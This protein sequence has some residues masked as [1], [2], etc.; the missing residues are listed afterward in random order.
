MRKNYSARVSGSPLQT[1][2]GLLF[3]A[4]PPN[5]AYLSRTD[6]RSFADGGRNK[7]STTCPPPEEYAVFCDAEVNV[8]RDSRPQ[9]WGLKPNLP[10]IGLDGRSLAKFPDPTNP[11]VDPWHGYPVSARDHKRQL[12]H[13]PES[14]LVD[15]WLALGLISPVQAARIK[16]GK[17]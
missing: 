12:E 15:R 17:I 9:L 1:P 13:T 11:A 2:A 10:E 6:H 14:S 7:W 16:R 8:W 5:S 4:D 3:D